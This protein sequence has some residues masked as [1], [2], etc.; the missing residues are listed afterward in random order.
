MLEVN[1]LSIGRKSRTLKDQAPVVQKMD[2]A[3]HCINHY[4][5]DTLSTFRTTGARAQNNCQSTEN[6]WPR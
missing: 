4:P 6:V 2:S 3:I 5:V 1:I